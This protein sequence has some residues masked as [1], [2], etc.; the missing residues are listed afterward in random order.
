MEG[1]RWSM[2][3]GSR[4]C[5]S[6]EAADMDGSVPTEDTWSVAGRTFR[7]R[8]ITGTG[9][10]KDYAQNAAAAAAAGVEMVTVAVRR[11][12]ISDPNQR[13]LVDFIDP[14]KYVYLPHT[15]GCY[16]ADDAQI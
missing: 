14:K 9:K 8:L 7:S 3:T 2:A 1:S 5:I 16:T 4:S 15:A 13:M 6:L 11:V 12:N 10:Y